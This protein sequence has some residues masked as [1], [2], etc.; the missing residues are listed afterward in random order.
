M[1]AQDP[2]AYCILPTVP[3]CDRVHAMEAAAAAAV[4]S[5][6]VGLLA[7]RAADV[8]RE[9]ARVAP[10]RTGQWYDRLRALQALREVQR[11]PYVPERSGTDCYQS[12]AYTATHG[13]ECKALTTLLVAVL[14]RLG[15]AARVEWIMQPGKALNHVTAQVWLDGAWFWAD[16]S[17]RGAML[18][19]SP[20]EALDRTGAYHVVGGR[21]TAPAGAP[22][23]GSS[24]GA[25]A[26]R[27]GAPSA[28]HGPGPGPSPEPSRLGGVRGVRGPVGFW[29]WPWWGWSGLWGGWPWWWW[30]SYYPY[31]YS[32]A[33]Y[34]AYYP[35]CFAY[36]GV[37]YCPVDRA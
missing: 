28:G 24:A 15:L 26:S 9:L 2:S 14:R 23:G 18:G 25:G 36:D 20:Y 27:V 13:G 6:E 11:L 35:A 4:G 5:P 21:P 31:L 8:A 1:P 37:V 32:A 33:Y 22:R 3:V 16:P 29:P 7:R 12:V 34:P 10:V 17:I 19:E 30:Y